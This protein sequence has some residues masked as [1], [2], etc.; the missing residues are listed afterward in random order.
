MSRIEARNVQLS[1]E[2]AT[3]IVISRPALRPQETPRSAFDPPLAIDPE[4]IRR[5]FQEYLDR[6]EEELDLKGFRRAVKEVKP[7]LEA[8]QHDLTE[9]IAETGLEGKRIGSQAI[10]GDS[11]LGILML[12][13]IDVLTE[14]DRKTLKR[15]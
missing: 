13:A 14:P 9:V 7:D 4:L 10:K 6:G 8:L 12:N 11:F 15:P 5:S 3:V 1:L 2:Q